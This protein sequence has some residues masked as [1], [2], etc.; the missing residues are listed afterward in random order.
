[1]VTDPP[2]PT[3]PLTTHVIVT[4]AGGTVAAIDTGADGRFR[5]ALRPGVYTIK[6]TAVPMGITR[7]ATTTVTV[8]SGR[9]QSLTLDLDSGIV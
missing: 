1:V 9:Y 2:C 4:N 3:Y 8:V 6:A 7:P 5:I